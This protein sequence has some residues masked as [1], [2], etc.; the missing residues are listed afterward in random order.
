M[1]N[2]LLV[3]VFGALLLSA[4]DGLGSDAPVISEFVV[5]DD[6]LKVEPGAV[7]Q[8]TVHFED[9]N[10]LQQYRVR[11]E[12]DFEGAR[13][14]S[15]L[16]E[17]QEDFALSGTS[18]DESLPIEMHYE[19]V[20]PGRYRLDIIVQDIDLNETSVSQHFYVYE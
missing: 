13:L 6:S 17:Y 8:F 12:D 14:L 16:W 7:L 1:K 11:I 3:L 9:D 19:D 15:A 20:E 18:V 10:G 2:S 5:L 4:C